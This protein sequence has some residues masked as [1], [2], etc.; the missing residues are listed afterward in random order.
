MF[1]KKHTHWIR[2][3]ESVFIAK[4]SETKETQETNENN[5]NT[6]I[7]TLNLSKKTAKMLQALG[8]HY[9]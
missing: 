7:K 3:W 9:Y 8:D 6:I 2:F 1:D 5:T 4:I